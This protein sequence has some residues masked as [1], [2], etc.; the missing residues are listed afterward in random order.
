MNFVYLTP[1]GMN[2]AVI[3]SARKERDSNTPYPLIPF[4]EGVTLLGRSI[5]IL[6]EIGIT[7]IYVVIGYQAE[8][9]KIYQSDDVQ[10]IINSNYEFTSSMASLAMVKDLIDDD[11][12]LVEG[13]TF[14]EKEVLKKLSDIQEGNCFVMT[15]ESGSGDECFVETK[16]GFITKISK[17]RHRVCRFEGELL[18]LSRISKTTFKKIVDKWE[19]S[20][21]SYLNY[22]YLMMDVTDVLDRPV[23]NFK[24]LIWGEVDNMKDFKKLQNDIYRKLR[25][26]ED[27]FDMDNLLM[28]LS[29]I[30]PKEDVSSAQIAQI[31]G[32][33]NKNFRVDYQGK[34]YVL[35]VPGNG[36][37]GMVVRSNEEFNSMEG[38]KIGINP[39]VHY[40]NANTGIKLVDYVEDAETL[41]TATIQRHDNMKKIAQ[42][43]RS[44]H[45]SRVRLKNEFNVFREIEKYDLLLEKAGA[46]MYEGW[47]NVRPQIMALESRLNDL[48][49]EL[50]P[51]HNDAVPE[52][53]LKAKD[54]TVYLID[55]EY[56][57]M[58]D[59]MA[60]IAALFLESNFTIENQE[61]MLAHYFEGKVPENA[62]PKILC[63]QALWDYLWAQWTVIKE[64]K[65]DD[66]G[67]YGRDR[68]HRTK[69]ILSR[70]IHK[71]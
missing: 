23:L 19:S 61:Y 55:W 34:S 8:Q 10:L 16:A 5:N 45:H 15:E 39:P 12:L 36:S 2:T 29:N 54:G 49:V 57:G 38:S 42:I 43:Y 69:E 14:Y 28:H 3:L 11:F 66:F 58:N 26:K 46:I 62:M 70:I 44:L 1:V 6:R 20:E 51:C 40:F 63:Y 60:D 52:N 37:E 59:P 67:T 18:G 56:S 68:Y 27:P 35:R 47:E 71:N 65:G 32:M 31:G 4:S 13:D 64:S 21:N 24:N 25:R 53:F 30:F 9:F 7:K 22:E 33:S 50:H 17:D 48:G 41:N